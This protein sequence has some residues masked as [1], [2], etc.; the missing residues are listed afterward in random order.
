MEAS[1]AERPTAQADE[2]EQDD[3]VRARVLMGGRWQDIRY[4]AHKAL[5]EL[6]EQTVSEPDVLPPLLNV[7]WGWT[8]SAQQG[9]L[10]LSAVEGVQDNIEAEQ[11]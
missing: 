1:T 4:S 5:P 9:E 3:M 6:I 10:V 11:F 8:R 7:L 2:Q